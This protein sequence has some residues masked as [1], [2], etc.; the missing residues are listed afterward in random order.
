MTITTARA[1][2]GR[3]SNGLWMESLAVIFVGVASF[4]AAWRILN[5]RLAHPSASAILAATAVA[6]ATPFVL[7]AC[8]TAGILSFSFRRLAFRYVVA[9]LVLLVVFAIPSVAIFSAL[10]SLAIGLRIASSLLI[11]TLLHTLFRYVVPTASAPLFEEYA[12]RAVFMGVLLTSALSG[13]S[14]VATP[15]TTIASF[16]FPVSPAHMHQLRR[17]LDHARELKERKEAKLEAALD[18][19]RASRAAN[20]KKGAVAAWWGAISRLGRTDSEQSSQIEIE[21]TALD[22]IVWAL[23]ADLV[24]LE[25]ETQRATLARTA[26]GRLSGA[27]GWLWAGYCL[28]RSARNLAFPSRE[29][30]APDPVSAWI[31]LVTTLGPDERERLTRGVSFAILGGLIFSGARSLDR[32]GRKA[33]SLLPSQLR[34]SSIL[35]TLLGSLFVGLYTLSV[36]TFLQLPNSSLSVSSTL[37]PDAREAFDRVGNGTFLLSAVVAV[38]LCSWDVHARKARAV[39]DGS[40]ALEWHGGVV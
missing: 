27:L 20:A 29:D 13:L 36:L 7:L 1:A 38:A 15:Y 5:A 10:G 25:A 22:A 2:S 14:A 30:S 8:E 34:P 19:E 12:A 40:V 28:L 33:L 26:S 32:W 23:Q 31:S 39:D 16:A 6:S 21:L 3:A 9:V 17:R 18:R 35:L 37:L 24:G 4:A 11:F